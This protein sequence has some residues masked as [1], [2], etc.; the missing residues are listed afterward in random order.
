MRQIKINQ[1]YTDRSATSVDQYISEISSYPLIS[2]EEECELAFAARKG[3]TIAKEKLIKANLRF[4]VSVAK[5][6][7]HVGVSL[8][9]LINEG[10]IGLLKAAEKFDETRGFKFI[11]YAVWWIRQSILCAISEH[12]RTIHL[13]YNRFQEYNI[14][15]EKSKEFENKYYCKPS[16]HQLSEL[17]NLS[18]STINA[19]LVATE[20]KDSLDDTLID[21]PRIDFIIGEYS[22]DGD[23]D[24]ESNSK[25]L[26]RVLK[27]TLDDREYQI[28]CSSFGIGCEQ[29]SLNQ[30]AVDLNMSRERV[31]QIKVQTLLKLKN[32]K[33][34]HKFICR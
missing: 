14:I 34:I 21:A 2:E 19:L 25:E 26:L 17:T 5:Q 6:Y 11:S 30:I 29:K 23:L 7:Q 10:N 27:R 15:R 18:E 13:P 12:G 4:V 24:K 20:S 22:A 9:D 3:D 31:R 16:A 33:L 1:R 28:I 8:A 32:N